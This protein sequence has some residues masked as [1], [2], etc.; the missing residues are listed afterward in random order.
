MGIFIAS[1]VI[2]AFITSSWVHFASLDDIALTI[3]V[4]LF[5]RSTKRMLNLSIVVHLPSIEK[6]GHSSSNA[7]SFSL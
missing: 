2:I 7:P 3:N 1:L 6:W 5:M 4:L